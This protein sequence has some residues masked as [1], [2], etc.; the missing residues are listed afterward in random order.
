M[1]PILL[2]TRK[3]QLMREIIGKLELDYDDEKEMMSDLLIEISLVKSNQMKIENYYSVNFGDET[4][5]SI[6]SEYNKRLRKAKL[7]DFDD[8]LILCHQLFLKRKDYLAAWQSKFKYILVDEFQ[9]I[10]K[11]QY[12]VI[13]MLA[14]P[15][16]NLLLWR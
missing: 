15:E 3:N 9:D 16:N 13:Q 12:Q 11:V 8:M 5:R 7:I 10:N 2:E 14:A 1:D 6:Y 4:F